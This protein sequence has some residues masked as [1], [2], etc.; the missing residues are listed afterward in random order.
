MFRLLH[1]FKISKL[2]QQNVQVPRESRV[3]KE[4]QEPYKDGHP[5]PPEGA[6]GQL[7]DTAGTPG[8]LRKGR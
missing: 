7:G 4:E 1:H 8:Q 6:G 5:S 3:Q 2:T